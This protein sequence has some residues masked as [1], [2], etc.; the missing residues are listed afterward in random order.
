[1]SMS[2]T[3]SMKKNDHRSF[4]NLT[5]KGFANENFCGEAIRKNTFHRRNS[6]KSLGDYINTG[7]ENITNDNS[8]NLRVADT[9]KISEISEETPDQQ[10]QKKIN[11]SMTSGNKNL[12]LKLGSQTPNHSDNSKKT[13]TWFTLS[14]KKPN[15]NKKNPYQYSQSEAIKLN[16]NQPEPQVNNQMIVMRKSNSVRG[17]FNTSNK[18]HD[19]INTGYN[20]NSNT[21]PPQPLFIGTDNYKKGVQDGNGNSGLVRKSKMVITLNDNEIFPDLDKNIQPDENLLKSLYFGEED[22][23]YQNL[24]RHKQTAGNKEANECGWEQKQKDGQLKT[25]EEQEDCQNDELI[26]SDAIEKLK[27]AMLDKLKL[28]EQFNKITY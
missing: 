4:L 21:S 7:T 15:S 13:P 22:Q 23:S 20:S 25:I 17:T 18:S 5:D 2:C 28:G 3:S 27:A 8:C 9:N 10:Q 26:R 14:N 1:M 16:N 12:D 19:N 11:I 6:S 24:G